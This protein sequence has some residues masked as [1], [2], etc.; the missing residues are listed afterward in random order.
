M[1]TKKVYCIHRHERNM[2]KGRQMNNMFEC[3]LISSKSIMSS[4]NYLHFSSQ[5]IMAVK[6]TEIRKAWIKG[7]HVKLCVDI[8]KLGPKSEIKVNWLL[9]ALLS[10]WIL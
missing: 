9:S 8:T 6:S 7:F 1:N 5:L 2:N 10:P 3:V 4:G